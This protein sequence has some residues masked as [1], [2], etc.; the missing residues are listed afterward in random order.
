LSAKLTEQA[1]ISVILSLNM[2]VKGHGLS[3]PALVAGLSIMFAITMALTL[4]WQVN[5]VLNQDAEKLTGLDHL[6]VPKKQCTPVTKLAFAK[7]HKTGGSTIHQC[8]VVSHHREEWIQC[9]TLHK[10]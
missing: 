6:I 2:T 3:K 4:F 7:T 1:L 8:G 10:H 5:P 9:I